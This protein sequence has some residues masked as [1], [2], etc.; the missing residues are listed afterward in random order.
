MQ[1]NT[2]IF[3]VTLILSTLE[4]AMAA[5]PF[6]KLGDTVVDSRALNLG[7]EKYGKMLFSKKINGCSF[8]QDAI[9]THAGHQY[10][11]Y[12]DG[13]RRVCIARRELPRGKW[14]VIRFGDYTFKNNDAHN[15]ISIGICPAD[16]TIHIAFDHHVHPLHYRVSKKGAATNPERTKWRASLFGP[17][18][19][20]LEKGKKIKVTYPRFWQTPDGS[21]QFCYRL[22]GSGNGDRMLVDY[23]P[24]SA[25]WI[26]TRQ[27]DSHKG[28]YGKSRSR[29]SYPNGYTYGPRGKLHTTWVW[30]EGAGQANHDLMYAYSEDRGKTWRNN[31]GKKLKEPAAVDSPGITVV[32]INE[33]YGLMNTH[34]QAVDS[35]GRIHAVMQHCDDESLKAAGSKPNAVRFGPSAAR[36]Y[37]HYFRELDGSWETRVLPGVAGN[38]PKVFIDKADDAHLIFQKGG[39]LVIMGAAASKSWKNWKILHTEKGPFINEMLG[40]YYRWCESGILSVMVQEKPKNHEPTSLR[41][42]DFELR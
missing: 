20:E 16:G 3:L 15:T 2:L 12:Y 4:T 33:A 40:D 5:S 41:I 28:Y 25:K 37:Y 18:L 24:V 21:L 13:K 10:V 7:D 34:G 26:N 42:I 1:I 23:D 11:G 29:C 6:N 27:I 39:N 14:E 38:R 35:R 19:S 8:Q 32:K 22:R 30:R 36:R 17:I 9:A 31:K